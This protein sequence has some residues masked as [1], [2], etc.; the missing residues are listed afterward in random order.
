[1]AKIKHAK[2]R[3]T[4]C[5]RMQNSWKSHAFLKGMQNDTATL[6]NSLMTVSYKGKLICST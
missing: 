1:M 4:K 6:K 3:N 5:G 2:C